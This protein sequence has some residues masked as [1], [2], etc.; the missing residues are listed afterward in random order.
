MLA[1]S[2]WASAEIFQGRSKVDILLIVFR[3]LAMQGK[4]MYTK[5]KIS[6]VAATVA[7]SVFLA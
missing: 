7:H 2:S 1:F 6:N 5:K 3:L 4:W